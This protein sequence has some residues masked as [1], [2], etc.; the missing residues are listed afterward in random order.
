M[1]PR[2]V[3]RGA[4]PHRG[5]GVSA[6]TASRPRAGTGTAASAAA[7]RPPAHAGHRQRARRVEARDLAAHDRRPRDH[8]DEHARQLDVGAEDRLAGD[9]TRAR[10]AAAGLPSVS[11]LGAWPQHDVLAAGTFSLP[12]SSAS[13]PKPSARPVGTWMTVWSLRDAVL[14]ADLPALRRRG[15]EHHA[16]GRARPG[17][18]PRRC[19]GCCSS[20]RCSGR[21]RLV[22]VGLQDLHA[23]HV[24]AELVGDQHGQRAAD[25]LAHL[26]AVADDGHRAVRARRARTRS[27]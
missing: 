16:R 10:R 17:A 13:S 24:R 21:R 19:R 27:G 2:D 6:T 15:D 14:R 11:Q 22:A 8:R 12:A 7:S 1:V 20:R 3:E 5:P 18:C 4:A 25:A 9:D 23:R 26:R